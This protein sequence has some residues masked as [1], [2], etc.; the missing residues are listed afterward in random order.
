M[1]TRET[2]DT[3]DEWADAVAAKRLVLVIKRRLDASNARRGRVADT[4]REA[5]IIAGG[6]VGVWPGVVDEIRG[7]GL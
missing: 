5:R 3:M 4:A 2:A 7:G 6:I 1:T